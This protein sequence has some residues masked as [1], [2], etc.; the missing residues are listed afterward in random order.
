LFIDGHYNQY[1]IIHLATLPILITGYWCITIAS[2]QNTPI[3]MAF[4]VVLVNYMVT[5]KTG[6]FENPN[7]N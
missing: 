1:D 3:E 4:V 5:Q 6:T 2:H 7:K